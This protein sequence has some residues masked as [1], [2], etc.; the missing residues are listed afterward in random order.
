MMRRRALLAASQTGGGGIE[1]TLQFPLYFDF[2]RCEI[3]FSTYC[4]RAADDTSIELENYLN[5]LAEEYGKYSGGEFPC[6]VLSESVLD[7]LG[8]TIYFKGFKVIEYTYWYG[9]AASE[10]SL[11][12]E[13]PLETI[14][15][16]TYTRFVYLRAGELFVEL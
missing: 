12:E 7:N 5:L 9:D 11:E 6:S 16:E 3:G 8:V 13:Y 1:T 14:W 10:L 2:D 4:T 15:G